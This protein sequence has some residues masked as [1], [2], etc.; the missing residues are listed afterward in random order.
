[1]EIV[2]K[3]CNTSYYISEDKIPLETKTGKCKKC[4]ASI[5]VLGKN[6]L[7]DELILEEISTTEKEFEGTRVRQF[8]ACKGSVIIKESRKIEVLQSKY[9][10]NSFFIVYTLILGIEKGEDQQRIFGVKLENVTNGLQDIKTIFIDFDELSELIEAIDFI[11]SKADFLKPQK[12]DVTE[13]TYA[14]KDNA[15]FGFFQDTDQKQTAFITIQEQIAYIKLSD[16]LILKNHLLKAQEHLI[17][18]GAS[19]DNY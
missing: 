6:E 3:N 11:Q 19:L 17:S 7:N 12:C 16:L 9:G 18:R 14:T 5:K 15:Q 13:L 10:K 8:L 1:M 4:G 2:C